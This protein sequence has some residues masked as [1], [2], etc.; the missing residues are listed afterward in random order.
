ML[1]L[2]VAGIFATAVSLSSVSA[3]SVERQAP[4]KFGPRSTSVAMIIDLP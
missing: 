4:R 3:Q 1:K 2:R